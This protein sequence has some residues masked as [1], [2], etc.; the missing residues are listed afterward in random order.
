EAMRQRVDERLEVLYQGFA[1]MK[2]AGLPVR[3][4]APQ[5]AIYLSVQFNLL[6]KAGLKSNDDIRK[7]LLDKASFALVPFQAFGLKDDTGWFRLS[8]GAVSVAEIREALPKVEA[9]VRAA[10]GG[11]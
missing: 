7:L 1:K 10:A 2:E 4:I 6:G 3:A 11:A 9:A 8:V 5:G